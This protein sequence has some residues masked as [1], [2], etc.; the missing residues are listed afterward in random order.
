MGC[1]SCFHINPDEQCDEEEK[2][3]NIKTVPNEEMENDHEDVSDSFINIKKD[4][5][6][7]VFFHESF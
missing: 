2:N 1:C 6:M 4:E 7:I 3:S 5:G